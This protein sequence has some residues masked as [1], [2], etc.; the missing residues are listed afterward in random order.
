MRTLGAE[1]T[2]LKRILEVASPAS[3][4]FA[5]AAVALALAAPPGH[6]QDPSP[7]PPPRF[8]EAVEVARVLI[9][10]RI[11]DGRGAALAD[12]SADELRVEVDGRRVA[13]E[14]LQWVAAGG[15]R[16]AEA[17]PEVAAPET[18]EEAEALLAPPEPAPDAGRLLVLFFQKDLERSRAPG[19]LRMRRRALELVGGLGPRDRVALLSFDSH[20]RFWLDFTGERARVV[21]ALDELITRP[22]PRIIDPGEPPSLAEHFDRARARRAASMESALRVL[23]EALEPIEGAKSLALFGGGIGRLSGG[24]VTLEDDYGPAVQALARARATVFAFDVTDADFHD[25][26]FGLQA[27]AA[28]TGGFYARTHTFAG[29]AMQRLERALSGHY[30]LAIPAPAERGTHSLRVRLVGRKGEVLVRPTFDN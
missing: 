2:P 20:L 15:V 27:V 7:S 18:L 14:S 28:D 13:A 1:V 29:Q 17:G 3:G 5:R 19:M 25:L 21:R 10:L 12:V 9:D 24:R 26:E 30:V 6:A 16:T 23:A 4:R 11:V 22:R 8:S